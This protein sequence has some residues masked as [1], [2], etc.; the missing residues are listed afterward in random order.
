VVVEALQLEQHGARVA[1]PLVRPPAERGLAGLHVGDRVGDRAC[2]ARALGVGARVRERTALGRRL[3]S[4]VLVEQ[5]QIE[6][7]DALTDDRE[8]EVPGLDHSGVNRADRDLVRLVSFDQ[9][10]PLTRRRRVRDERPQRLVS[11]EAHA[12]AVVRLAL[13]LGGGREHVE[14]RVDRAPVDRGRDDVLPAGVCE[15]GVE[16]QPGGAVTGVEPAEALAGGCT[17]F[18]RLAPAA[19]RD[20]L[21]PQR[22]EPA[23]VTPPISVGPRWA[24]TRRYPTTLS[25]N[26]PITAATVRRAV[27]RTVRPTGHG[28]PWLSPASVSISVCARPR[29]P[30]AR[31]TAAMQTT[32]IWCAATPPSR[33][34]SSLRNSGDGGSPPSVARL[35]PAAVPTAGLS[36]ASPRGGRSALSG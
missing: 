31:S 34:S 13:V 12:V 9:H 24:P 14:E 2:R 10:G 33:I 11:V 21:Q 4:A 23:H 3:Q 8:A 17:A 36:R 6:V 15:H 5:P 32:A 29:K 35:T 19:R 26:R 27:R 20:A 7:Q 16:L 30:S 25:A 1:R 22:L 28:R 18:T